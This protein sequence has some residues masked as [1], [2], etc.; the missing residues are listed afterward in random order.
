MVIEGGAVELVREKVS[1]LVREKVSEL[2]REKVIELVRE[3]ISEY[4]Y[5]CKREGQRVR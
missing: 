5:L 1:E 2:V 4:R 3:E